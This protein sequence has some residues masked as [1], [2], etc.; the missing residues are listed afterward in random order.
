MKTLADFKRAMQVNTE[1]EAFNHLYQVSMGKRVISNVRTTKFSFRTIREDGEVVDSWCA[2]PTA[3][4]I[5]FLE[6]GSVQIYGK[7]WINNNESVTALLL[8]YKKI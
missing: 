2:F 1:W 7:K 3:G 6:D 4:N 5:K 8:T